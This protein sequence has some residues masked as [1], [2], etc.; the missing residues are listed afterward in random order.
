MQVAHINFKQV[1]EVEYLITVNKVT[2]I[3][4][5]NE[6]ARIVFE[7]VKMRALKVINNAL[8]NKCINDLILS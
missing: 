2:V 3:K 8:Y 6:V 5:S 7:V 1:S 4:V